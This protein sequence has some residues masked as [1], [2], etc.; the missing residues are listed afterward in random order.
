MKC[1][2]K[3]QAIKLQ[4][5]KKNLGLGV[6]LSQW[7]AFHASLR[8]DSPHSHKKLYTA[9]YKS[10]VTGETEARDPW[11]S[12]DS[13][14]SWVCKLQIQWENLYQILYIWI[15]WRVIEKDTQCWHLTCMCM[16]KHTNMYTHRHHR[17]MH[18]KLENN[19]HNV[20]S[21]FMTLC[22]APFLV[23]IICM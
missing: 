2:L 17:H 11:S 20:L 1:T 8:T 16:H 22:W 7:S 3:N 19:F 12:L 10:P 21:N 15:K 5:E 18:T 14:S 13:Y 4:K 6:G 23:F 9:P